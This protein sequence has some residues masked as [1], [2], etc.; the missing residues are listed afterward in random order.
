MDT[1]FSRFD[2]RLLRRLSTGRDNSLRIV[3]E[4]PKSVPQLKAKAW[5]MMLLRRTRAYWSV[6]RSNKSTH[7]R[8]SHRDLIEYDVVNQSK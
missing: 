6:A 5:E 2:R 1:V 7:L 3:K 4:E 8:G